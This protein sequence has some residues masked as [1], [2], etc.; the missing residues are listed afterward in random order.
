MPI[1]PTVSVVVPVRNE[2]RYIEKVLSQLVS[3]DLPTGALE[4]VVADGR[5]VD[6][7]REVVRR[8]AHRYPCVALV[9]NPGKLAS[10]GRNI[11]VNNS[12]GDY[13]VIVDGHCDLKDRKYLKS[14]IRLFEISDADCLGRPQPLEGECVTRA[15]RAIAL[16][17]SSWVGHN[18][19]SLIYSGGSVYADPTS[20]AVAYRRGVFSRAGLFD[21]RF[22][23]CEDVELNHRLRRKGFSCFFSEAIRLDYAPRTTLAGLFRQMV[24]YGRGRAR[25]IRKHPDAFSVALCCPLAVWVLFIAV[26]LSVLFCRWLLLPQLAAVLA[27]FLALLLETVRIYYRRRPDVLTLLLVFAAFLTVHL[28]TATGLVKEL[29][30]GASSFRSE[31]REHS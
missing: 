8:F 16:A 22:D 26:P 6:D 28:G 13:V 23:A 18:P 12:S 1:A 31:R 4:V 3:Q 20:V 2:S 5:S 29:F 21:E 19:S 7:T 27:Y 14:I 15:Q 24:R 30:L 17:R 25:L 10:S 9:D 11:G